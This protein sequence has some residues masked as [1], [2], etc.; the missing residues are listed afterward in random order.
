MFP[1]LR[2]YPQIWIKSWVGFLIDPN[3]AT[4]VEE[5]LDEYEE[6]DTFRTAMIPEFLEDSME[7]DGMTI[8]IAEILISR[9]ICDYRAFFP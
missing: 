3:L 5:Y 9:G 4:T 7:M 6:D 1:R 8:V 2:A